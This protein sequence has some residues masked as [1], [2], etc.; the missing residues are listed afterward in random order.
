MSG[1][2]FL[3]DDKCQGT[4]LVKKTTNVRYMVCKKRQMSG[5]WFVKKRQMF[6]AWFVKK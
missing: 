2:W 5:T 3:K 6:A 4:R 1:T